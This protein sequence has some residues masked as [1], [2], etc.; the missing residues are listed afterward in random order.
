MNSWLRL[1]FQDAK[2]L[3]L[4]REE[5]LSH[6]PPDNS[7]PLEG[8]CMHFLVYAFNDG[9]SLYMFLSGLHSYFGSPEW[10]GLVF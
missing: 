3:V 4:E 10:S 9:Y 8:D 2:R 7:G 6:M 1:Q 5:E